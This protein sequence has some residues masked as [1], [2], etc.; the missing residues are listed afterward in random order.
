MERPMSPDSLA[1]E[2]YSSFSMG[3][4]LEG[5]ICASPS[6]V[7]AALRFVFPVY[8]ERFQP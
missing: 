7:R 5:L 1:G 8:L 6:A 2:L 4:G 3:Q